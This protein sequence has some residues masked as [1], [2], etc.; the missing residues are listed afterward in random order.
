MFLEH[1]RSELG[2]ATLSVVCDRVE[3]WRP[4]QRFDLVISRAFA[5]LADFVSLAGHLVAPGGEM[6]AMKG[7]YPYEEIAR[8]PATHRVDRVVPLRVP[9]LNAER[10]VVFVRPR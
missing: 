2:L 4:P 7:L 5:D 1:A 6:L 9:G 3:R 10:H 8:L